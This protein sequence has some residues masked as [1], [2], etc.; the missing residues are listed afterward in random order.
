ME[1]YVS[2]DRIKIHKAE[3]LEAQ[4]LWDILMPLSLSLDL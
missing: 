3:M 1:F 2:N 4:L